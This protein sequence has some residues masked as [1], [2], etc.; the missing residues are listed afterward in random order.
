MFPQTYIRFILLV[1]ICISFSEVTS[2]TYIPYKLPDTGQTEHYTTTYG[3][4][5][6]YIINPP[7]Y[8]DNGNGTVTDNNTG[9]MWQKSDGGE[10]IYE[11]SV[12]YCENLILGGYSDW[13]LP[14]SHELFSILNHQMLNPAMDTVYFTK[15]LAEYWWSI[16]KLIDNPF[17]VW[18]TNAGGGIGAHPRN[19]TISAGGTK[20]FHVKAVRNQKS[21]P[22]IRFRNN[23]DGTVTDLV[24]GLMWQKNL[25]N[26]GL[27][28]EQALSY[29]ESLSLAGYSDWRL[30]NIK[31]IQSLNNELFKSP[32]V[33]TGYFVNLSASNYWSSTT[34]LGIVEK[35]WYMSLDYGLVTYDV[36]TN[37]YRVI[38]VRGN[39]LQPLSL[40]SLTF[41]KGGEF[42]MGDHYGY[43]DPNGHPP[44]ETPIHLVH[45]DSMY[46]GTYITT[47]Q[48]Y[49]DY[50]NSA[51]SQ[52]LI[53]VRNNKVYAA[54]GDTNAYY[55]T[56]QF[57]SYY[58][59]GWNGTLFSVMDF[60]ANHPAVGVMWFG[61]AAYCNWMSQQLG[62]PVCYNLSTWSCDFTKNGIRL[63][64]EAEWEYAGRGGHYTPYYNYPWGN[65]STN[66]TI[67]NFPVQGDPYET[68]TYPY[69]TPVGF[70]DGQL[71]LKSVYNWPGTAASYQTSN[72][73]NSFGLYDMAGN[74]W[75]LINDWYGQYYYNW[76]PYSNPKGPN[77]DSATVMPDGKKYR[78][79]RGGNWWSGLCGWSRVSNR[80]PSYYR[81]PGTDWFH[82]GFRVARYVNA[83]VIGI[84]GNGNVIFGY[85]LY[86]NYPNPFNP[87]T[88]IKYSLSVNSL[89]KLSVIDILGKEVEILVN[90]NRP[91]G[92]YKISWNGS[93]YPSGVYFCR[94]QAGDFINTMKMI[95]LK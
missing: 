91:A 43:I 70:F 46:V 72:G 32:S 34:T 85:Q 95:L 5:A 33:D 44:D 12:L 16:D 64:T 20:R 4:D 24:S 41:I 17:N 42:M 28:W 11:N 54:T 84:F 69:T 59:I 58:S 15:T 61:A 27:T 76:S 65:D 23:N 87:V 67:A 3:E 68:G 56:Y 47:N 7:S 26:T 75:E 90:E 81:G 88:T 93:N 10:M 35:A 92:N 1:I 78:G 45:V 57:S 48:E 80:D 19:E 52:G 39:S 83:P 89:V 40:P 94:L 86:Q 37:L 74:T 36:K 51:K 6:D 53:A 82:V 25:N 8:T 50:L 31:E 38:C 30:P 22:V 71:K 29:C 73:M 77:I 49:C 63:L 14:N 62:L 18:V 55:F 13:R 60:R 9:L 79:M 21:N 2:Q 66:L